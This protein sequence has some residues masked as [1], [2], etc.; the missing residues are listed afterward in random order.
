MGRTYTGG[1]EEGAMGSRRGPG[2]VQAEGQGSF[3]EEVVL[4]LGLKRGERGCLDSGVWPPFVP[5][6]G[7]DTGLGEGPE[8]VEWPTKAFSLGD[9]QWNL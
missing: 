2:G 9:R 1:A 6:P 8:L 7:T 5:A 4:S 3:T